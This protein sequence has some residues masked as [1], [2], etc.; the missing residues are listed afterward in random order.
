MIYIISHGRPHNQ[1]TYNLLRQCGYTGNIKVVLDD[2]DSTM[3]EYYKELEYDSRAEVGV[4]NK[5]SMIDSTDTGMIEPMRNFAVFARNA[6][7]QDAEGKYKYFW[8]FDDDLTS[9]RLRYIDGDSLKSQKITSN[10][11]VIFHMIEDYMSNTNISTIGFGT[12]NNY[13]SGVKSIEKESS[14][15]RMCYNGYLRNSESPVAWSLNMCEDRITSILQN[16]VGNIWMQLLCLQI[17]T[18]PL[19]GVVEGGNSEVYRNMDKFHQVF[20]PIMTSP[21]CNYVKVMNG[22]WFTMYD[23]KAICPK[24]ISSVYKKEK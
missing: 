8:V 7:E 15:Y 16:K 10:L 4:F 3:I 13:M 17:D 9:F 20:F 12:A 24:I 5:Q 2:E 22:K 11:D 23:E 14:K 6:V 18:M 21:D 19:G 1:R